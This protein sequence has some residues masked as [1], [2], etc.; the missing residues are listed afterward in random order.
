MLCEICWTKCSNTLTILGCIV[1]M[2][3]RGGGD[4]CDHFIGAIIITFV[5][6]IIL[7]CQWVKIRVQMATMTIWICSLFHTNCMFHILPEAKRICQIA[8]VYLKSCSPRGS[9]TVS[10]IR[11]IW[12]TKFPDRECAS[13]FR[14][15]F[16]SSYEYQ[17]LIHF[18]SGSFS[19]SLN[20]H[21]GPSNCV[22]NW[23]WNF[24]NVVH[25]RLLNM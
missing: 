8:H 12:S 19:C 6:N 7:I 9:N 16:W 4:D 14:H 1:D 22:H 2:I 20:G 21:I 17:K 13:H 15:N 10:T 11:T 5:M 3:S 23:A 18:R 24:E 25:F